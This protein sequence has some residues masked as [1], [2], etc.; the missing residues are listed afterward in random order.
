MLLNVPGLL[1]C[2]EALSGLGKD[3]SIP[4][5]GEKKS[6]KLSKLCRQSCERSL[7]IGS[8]LLIDFTHEA[9]LKHLRGIWFI[10]NM[11][12]KRNHKPAGRLP[13]FFPSG[14]RRQKRNDDK[15]VNT[16]T[17]FD[18]GP[19]RETGEIRYLKS[20]FLSTVHRSNAIYKNCTQLSNI[21][22]LWQI[23][24]STTLLGKTS[25]AHTQQNTT[26]C[27]G[28]NSGSGQSFGKGPQRVADSTVL[29]RLLGSRPAGIDRW[30]F[31]YLSVTYW[32]R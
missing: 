31:S 9:H 28:R 7:L 25:T 3:T 2:S 8:Y 17:A 21:C 12:R 23:W 14:A 13:L 10:N 1:D 18:N 11:E 5:E 26:Q 22:S 15:P 24:D 27:L 6:I 29:G 4:K 16:F 19:E 20:P 32:D 30:L